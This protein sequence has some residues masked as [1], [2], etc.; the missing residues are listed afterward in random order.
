MPKPSWE[1]LDVFLNEDDFAV[2]AV[3]H[4][5]SGG[6]I[7]L[8]IIYDS[9]YVEADLGDSYVMDNA[10]PRVTCKSSLVG[11]VRRGDTIVVTFPEGARTFDILTARQSTGTGIAELMLARP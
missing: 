6:Q 4:L 11:A 5:Q 3:I 9:P 7:A 8:S 2:P 1:N 10:H